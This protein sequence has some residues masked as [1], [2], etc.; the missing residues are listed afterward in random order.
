MTR[1]TEGMKKNYQRKAFYF[2][3][4]ILEQIIRMFSIKDGIIHVLLTM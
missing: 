3:N 1:A 2:R 4:H